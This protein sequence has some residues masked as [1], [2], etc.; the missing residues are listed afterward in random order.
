MTLD[1]RVAVLEQKVYFVMQTLSLTR[2]LPNGKTDARS[3]TALFKEMQNHGGKTSQTL[4]EVAERAFTGGDDGRPDRAEG[5]DG[6]SGTHDHDT[7]TA[8][9]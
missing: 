5:P 4:T 2:Q 9:G 7:D 3:L 6:Y 8:T 1:E